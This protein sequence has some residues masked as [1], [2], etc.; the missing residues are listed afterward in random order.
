[1]FLMISFRDAEEILCEK[2]LGCF[3]IR[4]SNKA[5]GYIL[6]YKWVR[7]KSDQPVAEQTYSETDLAW[8]VWACRIF[9]W[10]LS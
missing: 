6:S 9:C 4:L 10:S 8:W 5:I 1:M 7:L 3:L 2:E